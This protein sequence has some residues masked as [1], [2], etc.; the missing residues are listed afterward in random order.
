[1]ELK[2]TLKRK[3][4]K[5][6]GRGGKRGTYAGRGLKGQK[7]H[8]GG[9][10]PKSRIEEIFKFPKLRGTKNKPAVPTLAINVSDLEAVA[11]DGKITRNSITERKAKYKRHKVKILGTGEVK[12]AFTIEGVKASKTAKEKIEKAGGSVT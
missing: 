12:G 2:P 10:M 1:M 5:R 6:V 9:R 4:R 3:K 11:K 8:S 7:A